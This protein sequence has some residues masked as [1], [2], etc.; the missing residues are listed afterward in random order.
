VWT[1]DELTADQ[2][3]LL[4]QLREIEAPAPAEI[5]RGARKG[6]LLRV[7]EVLTGG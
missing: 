6:F 1:P 5:R 7:K 2:E 3:K 4:R